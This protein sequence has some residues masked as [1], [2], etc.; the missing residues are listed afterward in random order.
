MRCVAE[1]GIAWVGR[2]ITKHMIAMGQPFAQ[3]GAAS[4]WQHGISPAIVVMVESMIP[5]RA[6][7]TK[8]PTINP[9]IASNARTRVI[10]S[11][12]GIGQDCQNDDELT[13]SRGR[14]NSRFLLSERVPR[15]LDIRPID[16]L[17]RVLRV[18]K[19]KAWRINIGA[20]A[21][22]TPGERGPAATISTSVH[23]HSQSQSL[24]CR[25][26]P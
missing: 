13:R 25:G 7:V 6:G 24:H 10:A 16:P 5:A 23:V 12:R 4:P 8:E 2:F 3:F 9:R 20:R 14:E 17:R 21:R 18:R 19:G 26:I 15:L 1:V 11:H 22:A